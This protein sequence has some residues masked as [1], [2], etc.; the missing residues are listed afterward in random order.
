MMLTIE[1]KKTITFI[2]LFLGLKPLFM[3]DLINVS[4]ID[5]STIINP[6]IGKL[7]YIYY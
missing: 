3:M 2:S 7:I 6:K 1:K 4:N 5:I